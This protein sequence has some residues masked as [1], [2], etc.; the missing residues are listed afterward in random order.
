MNATFRLLAPLGLSMLSA[1]A[2]S[3][4]I[5]T[6]RDPDAARLNFKGETVVAVAVMK[7]EASRRVAEDQL[8]QKITKRGAKGRTMYS[9]FPSANLSDEAASRA[10]LEK[11]GVHGVIVMRPV[12]VD[13]EV[14]VTQSTYSEPYYQNYWGG[15]YGYGWGASYGMPMSASSST[16]TTETTVVYIET[17]VYSLK[18]NK[19]VWAGR[20]KATYADKL[21]AQVN[22]LAD[23]LTSELKKEKLIK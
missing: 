15:Y 21:T 5:D 9:M 2:S 16:R 12:N 11:A 1:C 14:S 19:L 7:G 23:A 4:F 17:L 10:A 13:K 18:D 6:W 3:P 8:A 22:E 20:S